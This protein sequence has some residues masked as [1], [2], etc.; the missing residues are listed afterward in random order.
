[1][2]GQEKNTFNEE[3][4][5][6]VLRGSPNRETC[7]RIPKIQEN[8][9]SSQYTPDLGRRSLGYVNATRAGGY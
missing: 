6:R 3:A 7:P 5:K 1:M 4:D 8:P 2:E 9:Q